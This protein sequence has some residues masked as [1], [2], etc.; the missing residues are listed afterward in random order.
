MLRVAPA[1][2]SRRT[3]DRD[4]AHIQPQKGS[5]R[6]TVRGEE[7]VVCRSADAYM[8]ARVPVNVP[9][10]LPDEK[11]VFTI[12]AALPEGVKSGEMLAAIFE[13]DSGAERGT[14][15][16]RGLSA[17][18]WEDIVC[19]VSGASL[20]KKRGNFIV[21]IYKVRGTDAIAVSRVSWK[22]E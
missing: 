10:I 17:K 8:V 9:R 18:G 15:A 20:K 7:A 3:G 14:L 5:S 11:L 16:D 4:A 19:R 6:E 22:V 13:A 12:R 21:I 1:G 2:P